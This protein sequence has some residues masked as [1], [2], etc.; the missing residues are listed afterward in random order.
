MHLYH[1]VTY[2]GRCKE[3]SPHKDKGPGWVDQVQVCV[4]WLAE[5]SFQV[6]R[7]GLG[8]KNIIGNPK[9]VGVNPSICAVFQSTLSLQIIGGCCTHT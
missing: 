7:G 4:C 1:I 2:V 8:L 6:I 3:T 9:T 5:L